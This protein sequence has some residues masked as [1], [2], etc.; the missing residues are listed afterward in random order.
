VIANTGDDV[1]IYGVHVSPDPDLV[2]YWLADEIDERGYGLRGDTF[3]VMGAL[4]RAGRPA[5]FR[6]GDR[7]LAMCLI[8]SERLRAGGRL[9]EA[10]A[11]VVEAMGVHARVLPMCDEP[12]STWVGVGGRM[13]PFQEYMIV[14]GAPSPIEAVE[15]RGLE[16]ARPSDEVLLALAEAEVIVIGPSNPVASIGPILALPGTREA[17][18]GSPAPVVAVSPLVGGRSLKGPTE[19]FCAFA[20]I[21][22]SADGIARAY[23]EVL[24]GMVA[25]EE[26]ANVA[27]LVADTVLDT[28]AA[29]RRLAEATLEFA[30]TLRG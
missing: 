16:T 7:D 30:A 6:L 10:H 23:A 1:D 26:V 13:L 9:T 2:T 28:V 27:G 29:S 21:E 22:L 17:L 15:L 3:E 8:R 5:W 25:D 18:A 12:V 14:E 24:D 11:A 19:A 20:G 4:E